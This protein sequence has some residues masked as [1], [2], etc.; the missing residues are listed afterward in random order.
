MTFGGETFFMQI[1]GELD[2]ECVQDCFVVDSMREE[3]GICVYLEIMCRGINQELIL[4]Y[5]DGIRLRVCRILASFGLTKELEEIY[6]IYS[7]VNRFT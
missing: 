7:L 2:C 5:F 3:L 1:F 4:V 6:V